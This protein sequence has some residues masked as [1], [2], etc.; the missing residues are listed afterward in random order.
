MFSAGARFPML[1]SHLNS[2]FHNVLYPASALAQQLEY[3]YLRH[4]TG[5][6]GRWGTP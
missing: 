1:P 4:E 5:T 3:L 2:L 6:A